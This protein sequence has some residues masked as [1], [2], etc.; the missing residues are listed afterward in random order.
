ML[1]FRLTL[2]MLCVFVPVLLQADATI[3]YSI[4]TV[5][6]GV[7]PRTETRVVRMKDT[8]GLTTEGTL[9]TVIDF[10]RQQVTVFDS[11]S[12]RYATLS[13]AEY[14]QATS[15]RTASVMPAA[16][17]EMLKSMKVTCDSKPPAASNDVAGVHTM[18]QDVNCNMTMNLPNMPQMPANMPAMSGMAMKISMRTWWPSDEERV[19]VPGLWQADRFRTSAKPP[20]Q[21]G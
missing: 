11:A 8:K 13:I 17:T 3:R 14:T 1:R 9:T 5:S 7:A 20:L 21:R 18:E 19:R 6:G 2:P 4:Q 15:D 10:A 12:R 16:A